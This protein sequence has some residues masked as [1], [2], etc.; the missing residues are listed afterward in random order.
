MS[1]K[2]QVEKIKEFWQDQASTFGESQLATAP[3]SY[4][5]ELEIDRIMSYLSDGKRILDIGCGNGF[6]TFFFAK[7]FPKSQFFGLDYSEKMIEAAQKT[8]GKNKTLKKR[9]FFEVGSVLNLGSKLP[10]IGKFDLI[11]S[12]RCLINLMNW[13]EQKQALLEMKKMLKPGGQIILCE[14]TQEGLSRLNSLRKIFS[15]PAITVRWHNYYMPEKKLLEFASK[16]FKVVDVNN[17]GSLY[18]IISRVVHASLSDMENKTPEY[19]HPINKIASKLPSV[20]NYSPN[21]IFL[22]QKKK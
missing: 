6:S 8:L 1:K 7:K 5:R 15:L 4:Y 21:F 13:Q 19:L 3:D 2:Q 16:N 14:N 20:G 17:I 9:L 11:V 22:L 18:Y 10:K 12:E